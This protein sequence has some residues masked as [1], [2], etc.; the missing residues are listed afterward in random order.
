MKVKQDPRHQNRI[1]IMQD[2]YAW[3]FQQQN[4]PSSVEANQVIAAQDQIDGWIKQAAPSWPIEQINKIDLAILR[5]AVFELMLDKSAPYKVVIDE[6]VE[7]GKEFGADASPA[8]IN[9]AL[10]NL[11]TLQSKNDNAKMVNDRKE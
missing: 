11:V 7:L 6:A 5:L 10:G 4:S 3:D 1:K 2:L 9:G 8:F